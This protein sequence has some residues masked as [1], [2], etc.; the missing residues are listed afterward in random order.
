MLGRAVHIPPLAPDARLATT[1]GCV[2]ALPSNP[3]VM[4]ALRGVAC[5]RGDRLLFEGL[6]LD[7]GGRRGARRHRPQRHRQVEPAPHRRGS[8]AARRPGRSRAPRRSRGSARRA[9]STASARSARR[10]ASGRRSTGRR[11]GR[12]WRRWASRI[13]R[14]C[15]SAISRPASAAAPRSRGRS[16]APRRSGC[17]TNPPT[18]SMP[19]VSSG[20]ATQWR[21]TGPTAARY[22][23]P[24]TCHC[25]SRVRR[26]FSFP[27][28]DGSAA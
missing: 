27:R 4:L 21:R 24:R 25:R 28:T 8:A 23:R 16:P 22:W 13:S 12:R 10:W 6:D 3:F 9:R 19:R 15:P 14:A 18:G 11:P 7:A 26:G 1:V 2:I 5:R 20:S 17:S